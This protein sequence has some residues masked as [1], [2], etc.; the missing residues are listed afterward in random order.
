MFKYSLTFLFF[1]KEVSFLN[2]SEEEK[3]H[4]E[5]IGYFDSQVQMIC[6]ILSKN[7]K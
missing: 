1:L 3:G 6:D 7:Y 5:I 2:D 4:V